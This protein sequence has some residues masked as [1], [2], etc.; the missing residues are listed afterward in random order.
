MRKYRSAILALVMVGVVGGTA[1][2]AA[3]ADKV[4]NGQWHLAALNIA[5]AH[6][7]SP[8]LGDGITIGI[9]DT[10]V[11]GSHPDLAGNVLP[12]LDFFG[13]GT[14]AWTDEDGHGTGMAGLAVAHGHGTDEGALGIAPRAK[15]IPVRIGAKSDLT[16][17]ITGT[18]QG[19][20]PEDFA[21]G[22]T[23]LVD[24]G[25]RIISISYQIPSGDTVQAAIK[26]AKARGLL[27]IISAGNKSKQQWT[28]NGT[29]N[30]QITAGAS[31]RNGH[32]DP[33]TVDP[34]P[35]TRSPFSH[36]AGTS[37]PPT[38]RAG[39]GSVPAPPTRRRS[40]PVRRR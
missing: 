31:D 30:A 11:D 21:R 36:Q 29:M 33:I 1:S 20:K 22:I 16:E 10:G 19:I 27:V 25:V 17:Q 26:A 37:C 4:R 35:F 15:V 23:W 3:A 5:E 6:R 14:K 13:Q 2:P 8:G 18:E 38:G 12:G 9:I 34:G 39:T 32:L 7:L 40:R 24:Q 28:D